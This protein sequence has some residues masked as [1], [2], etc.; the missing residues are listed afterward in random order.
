MFL[1]HPGDHLTP[2][3]IIIQDFLEEVGDWNRISE[4]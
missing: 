4:S 2:S 1:E 3:W